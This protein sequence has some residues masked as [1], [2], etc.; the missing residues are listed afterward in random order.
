M[1]LSKNITG[2]TILTAI[3]WVVITLLGI[4]GSWYPAIVINILLMALYIALGCTKNGVLDKKLFLYPIAAFAVLWEIGFFLTKYY[5]DM[6]L[7]KAPDFT[8]MGYHPSF[9]YVVVFYWIGGVLTLSVGHVLLKDRWLSE[10]DWSDFQN[11]LETIRKNKK[12]SQKIS[13]KRT[14]KGEM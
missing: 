9:F 2:I 13:S 12:Q 10:K 1:N 11:K 3:L 4:K 7:D 8:I 14:I 6:F 5:G